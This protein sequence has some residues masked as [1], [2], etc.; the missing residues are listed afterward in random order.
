MSTAI[1]ALGAAAQKR[2]AWNLLGCNGHASGRMCGRDV[3]D[4]NGVHR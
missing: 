2:V 1:A 4:V 3:R